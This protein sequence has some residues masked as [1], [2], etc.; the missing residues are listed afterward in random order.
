[1]CK[2]KIISKTI[3]KT[4]DTFGNKVKH[5]IYCASDKAVILFS[6][7]LTKNDIYIQGFD[8]V[9]SFNGSNLFFKFVGLKEET[10]NVIGQV[11]F[12]THYNL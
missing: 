10:L 7:V 2:T 12:K 4:T 3:Y 9:K 5:Y 11:Q 6:Y 8:K 1:M